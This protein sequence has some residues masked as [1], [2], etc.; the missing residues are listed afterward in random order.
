[1]RGE[2]LRAPVRPNIYTRNG[3]IT[4]NYIGVNR[5]ERNG[6]SAAR[7]FHI[8][9]IN[10]SYASIRDISQAR[11]RDNEITAIE[12]TTRNVPNG[13]NPTKRMSISCNFKMR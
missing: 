6:G 2:K 11:S 13:Y 4:F 12:L 5:K 9:V 1:M 7:L 8:R 3:S 10:D